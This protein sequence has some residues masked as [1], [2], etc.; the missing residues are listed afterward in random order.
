MYVNSGFGEPRQASIDQAAVDRRQPDRIHKDLP[1]PPDQPL[2]FEPLG[3][4]NL[5]LQV[6]PQFEPSTKSQD[7]IVLRPPLRREPH[8]QPVQLPNLRVIPPPQHQQTRHTINLRRRQ[9]LRLI[10]LHE[11]ED[12]LQHEDKDDAEEVRY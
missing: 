6:S 3:Q 7:P 5:Q 9:S 10:D 4:Q 1:G 8:L 2:R 11:E 12:V